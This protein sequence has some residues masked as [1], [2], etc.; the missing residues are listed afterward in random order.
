MNEFSNKANTIIEAGR[1]LYQMGMVPATS[2]NFSARLDN[3]DIAITVSGAHK[4]KLTETDIMLISKDGYPLDG[5]RPSAETGLHVQIYQQF[6]EAAVVLHPHAMNAVLLS[7]NSEEFILLKNYELLKAFPGIRTHDT[8]VAIPVFANDQDIPRLVNVI[9]RYLQ[10][11]ANTFA[12]IIA[13]HGFYT[14]GES[15]EEAM[16]YVEALDYLFACELKGNRE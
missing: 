12:Y 1:T 15:I 16:R 7:R 11:A 8:T 13:G 10:Q 9:D 2:G 4:G 3:G 5:R 14:W 6:P